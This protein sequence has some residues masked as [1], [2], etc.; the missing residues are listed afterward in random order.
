MIS[1]FSF[2]YKIQNI[3]WPL[4]SNLCIRKADHW[5]IYDPWFPTH[6]SQTKNISPPNHYINLV[7]LSRIF[8]PL[9]IKVPIFQFAHLSQTKLFLPQTLCLKL[10]ALLS[11]REN[12][13]FSRQMHISLSKTQIQGS[14][15][16]HDD[17]LAYDWDSYFNRDILELTGSLPF[18]ILNNNS[19]S[20]HQVKESIF[21]WTSK[22]NI[23]D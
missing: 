23:T 14:H 15:H 22:K 20:Y 17:I 10:L 3:W 2:S 13:P 9:R 4:G 5:K 7:P 18:Q 19:K 21:I 8:F 12:R 16:K 6:Q 11:T 1:N